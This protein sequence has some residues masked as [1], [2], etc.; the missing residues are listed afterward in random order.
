MSCNKIKDYSR[1]EYFA[2]IVHLAVEFTAKWMC[3]G[4]DNAQDHCTNV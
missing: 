4:Y 2:S 1:N 3:E